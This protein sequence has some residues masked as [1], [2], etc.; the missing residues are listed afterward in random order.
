M[1][2]EIKII[3]TF[4]GLVAFQIGWHWAITLHN[5]MSE[6]GLRGYTLRFAHTQKGIAGILDL[7]LPAVFIGLV[8]GHM[9]WQWRIWKFFG[10]VPAFAVVLA[11]LRPLY[12]LMITTEKAWWWPKDQNNIMSFLIGN[13]I[14]TSVIIAICVY[15]GR[16]SRVEG[17]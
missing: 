11:A 7:V 5:L 12:A 3:V 4:V 1:S 2:K 10:Y 8:M 14:G 17:R 9:G 15:G 13:A 6:A 16:V